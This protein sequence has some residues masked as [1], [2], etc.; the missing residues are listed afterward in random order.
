[1]K[2]IV[3]KA[4]RQDKFDIMLG[5]DEAGR[6]VIVYE[7]NEH[8]HASDPIK[9]FALATFMFDMKLRELEGH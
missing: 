6:Y 9:D 4:I 1:M 2:L 5:E 7:V 8:Q 3:I